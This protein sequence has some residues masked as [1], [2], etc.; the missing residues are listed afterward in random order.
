MI[1]NYVGSMLRRLYPEIDEKLLQKFYGVSDMT[2]TK[3][4]W[5]KLVISKLVSK[6]GQTWNGTEHLNLTEF[7]ANTRPKYLMAHCMLEY[8]DCRQLWEVRSKS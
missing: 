1:M 8:I 6:M 5:N 2:M 3:E 4:L 7:Y